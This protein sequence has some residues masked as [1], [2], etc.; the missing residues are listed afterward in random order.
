MKKLVWVILL[1]SVLMGGYVFKT[2]IVASANNILYQSPCET[3]KTF[4]IGNIDKKYNITRE[5][6]IESINDAGKLWSNQYGKALFIYDPEGD[7]EVNLVYD[8]RQFLSSQ[9]N[10][11][12]TKVKSQ[13]DTLDPKIS[14]YQ[15]RTAEFRT[16]ATQ[17]NAEIEMWNKNGGAPPDEYERLKSRQENLRIEASSLQQEAAFLNQSTDEYNQQVGQ[18]QQTVNSFNEQLSYKPEEG[19]YI[20]DN[21]QE[22]INIYFDNSRTQLIHTLAHELGHSL[23][24]AHNNNELSIMYPQ[25]TETITLTIEDVNSLIK[26]CER[27]SVIEKSSEKLAIIIYQLRLQL[28]N[29]Q[30]SKN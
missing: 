20:Y 16:K 25:S 9:I 30:Q 29:A 23:E 26:A 14:D 8:Q 24:I 11:L 27:R 6:F 15:K 19:E 5:E 13:Q 7:I 2:P 28:T 4:R 17:L 10:D 18:L 12:N 3:P 21:G 1:F 22:T